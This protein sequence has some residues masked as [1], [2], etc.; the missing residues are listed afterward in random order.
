MSPCNPLTDP[1]C[2]PAPPEGTV[3]RGQLAQVE[4]TA[5]PEPVTTPQINISDGPGVVGQSKGLP[6]YKKALVAIGLGSIIGVTVGG[7]TAG[8]ATAGGAA[9]GGVT[10]AAA[11]SAPGI[12][13]VI[14][15]Q[16]IENHGTVI[17][18]GNVDLQPTFDRIARGVQDLHPRDNTPFGNREALLPAQTDPGY[19]TEHVVRTPG[20]TQVGP[21]RIITGNG[22]EVWYTPDHY[23]TFTPLNDAARGCGCGPGASTSP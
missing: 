19:Y 9:A 3:A 11:V 21:Q 5:T 4:V 2:K 20:I 13:T 10:A 17:G 1:N 22:G 15:G 18:T 14:A 23:K 16:R 7:T 6:W 12:T 8:G